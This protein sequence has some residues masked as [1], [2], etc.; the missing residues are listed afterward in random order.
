MADNAPTVCDPGDITVNPPTECIFANPLMG[1]AGKC[2]IIESDPYKVSVTGPA[3]Q[4]IGDVCIGEGGKLEMSGS[5][6]IVGDV[7]FESAPVHCG[8]CSVGPT[9]RIRGADGLSG[10][11]SIDQTLVNDA[12]VACEDAS[13]DNAVKACTIGDYT[14]SLFALASPT[15]DPKVLRLTGGPG[16]NV[17]CVSDV[18]V[19]GKNLE[20]AG[21]ATTT[22]VI[23]VAPGGNFKINGSKIL[24]VDPVTPSDVLYNVLGTGGKVAFS[25]GGGGEGCCKA[26]IDGT[27][28]AI[29]REIALAPGL[30]RGQLCGNRKIDL[31]SG[32]GVQ[33]PPQ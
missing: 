16:E 18:E 8:G 15:A 4:I 12:I 10:A 25:G 6:Y 19:S 2:T 28:I 23:N 32:S 20:L 21:D 14:Q 33:C 22:F 13:D 3:A 17:V 29:E 24:A 11:I 31:V 26:S 5:N 27:L 7:Y 30:I 1:V 9:G